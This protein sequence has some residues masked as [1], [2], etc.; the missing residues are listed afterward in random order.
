MVLTSLGLSS[1]VG[2]KG[3]RDGLPAPG[4]GCILLAFQEEVSIPLITPQGLSVGDWAM[5]RGF[6]HPKQD[7]LGRLG[8]HSPR[9]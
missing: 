4:T 9:A 1:K 5:L 8:E 3:G 7:G 2:P 6:L